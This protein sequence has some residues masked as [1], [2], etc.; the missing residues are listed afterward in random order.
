M[1]VYIGAENIVSPLGENA[2]ENFTAVAGGYSGVEKKSNAGFAGQNLYLSKFKS[3]LSFDALLQQC[4]DQLNISEDI[5]QSDK[6]KVIL[7]ST[8]GNVGT[9]IEESLTSVIETFMANNALKSRPLL[10][11]NACISGVL[12][13]VKAAD[14]IKAGLYDHVIVLGCDLASDFIVY[15][16]E[17]L[18]A[19][20]DDVC[21][22]YDKDRK[23]INLGEAAA[24]VVL[25][26]DA[27]VFA[28][29]P[30]V[31]V[32][33]SSSND[34]NHISGPSRTGEGLYRSV[35]RT[36]KGT[37]LK[38]TDV[39]FISAHGTAT[40]YNDNMESIAFHRLGM[41][42]I[43]LNSFK[44]YFG[45]TLGAAGVLEV[46]MTI[47]SMQ[48]QVLIKSLGY[49]EKGTDYALNII[50]QTKPAKINTI[51]KTSS[52]FGGANATLM[53]KIS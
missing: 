39:D 2:A 17:A 47:Q 31:Y 40:L 44:A 33:G 35:L 29:K 18:Y 15:G 9:A 12:A 42:D 28:E 30:M 23:G 22:P 21:K 46:A 11:S 45:H 24:G 51:L 19:L 1:T 14:M 8:K 4:Y 6:T 34:A 5:K 52:G 3:P 43:P 36:L 25:S 53:L 13:I 50:K 32:N 49:K 20:A 16:F 41:T 27:N 10:V 7:S 48:H 26:N 38:A 37:G